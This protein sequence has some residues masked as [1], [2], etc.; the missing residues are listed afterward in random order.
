MLNLL[1]DA[2]VRANRR[3][4]RFGPPTTLAIHSSL[5]GR[6]P[7]FREGRSLDQEH[8]RKVILLFSC[9][10]F[11][12]TT[13]FAGS[14]GPAIFSLLNTNPGFY[15]NRR[16]GKL[17]FPSFISIVFSALPLARRRMIFSLGCGWTVPVK[18]SLRS[19]LSP[20]CASRSAME[21]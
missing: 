6:R 15:S 1:F 2:H 16:R 21:V 12:M 20:R 17:V 13:P 10:N 8:F 7:P 4:A 3:F 11:S 19:G 9:R 14:A 5:P 18:C